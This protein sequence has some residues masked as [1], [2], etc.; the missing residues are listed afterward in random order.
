MKITKLEIIN[1]FKLAYPVI[2]G[3]LGIVMMGVVDSMMVGKLGPIPLAA[4]SL[5]NSLIFLILII[6]IGSSIVVSPLVAILVGAKRY[7]ECGVYF[8]Q[9][10]VVNIAVSIVMIVIILLGVNFIY[11]LKQPKEV[12]DQTIIFMTIVGLSALPLMIY[13]TY[14]QFIEGLS[15]MK[16]AMIIA[17]LANIINLLGNWILIFGK[18]GL[19][20]L[21][22]AGSA[23]ATFSS[24]V[25]M[26]VALMIYVMKNKKFR[27]YDV[28]FHFRGLDFAI[29]KKILRLGLPS[30]FLWV[31][32]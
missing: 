20:A 4:A 25:F 28:T 11:A 9:S 18:L 14:K 10:L 23:W 12:I 6:G 17:L 8:R 2:I 3:Q 21:G 29:I 30:G 19:P 5:G 15:V 26:A 22:I 1:T 32:A 31:I 13:Q 16:P 24:R 27:Q 7:S